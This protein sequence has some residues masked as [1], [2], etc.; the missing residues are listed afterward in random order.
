[1]SFD[2]IQEK[3]EE[4]RKQWAFRGKFVDYMRFVFWDW[5]YKR[6]MV[7]QE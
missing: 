5:R 2:R 1:M 7:P 3:L 4:A 6:Q